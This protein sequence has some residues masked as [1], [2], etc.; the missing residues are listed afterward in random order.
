MLSTRKV[1]DLFINVQVILWSGIFVWGQGSMC[2]KGVIGPS[3]A[4]NPYLVTD[5]VANSG[6]YIKW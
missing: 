3:L 4:L 5:I 1:L 2:L 6:V